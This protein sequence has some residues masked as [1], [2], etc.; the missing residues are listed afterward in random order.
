M[1]KRDSKMQLEIK[2]TNLEVTEAIQNYLTEKLLDLE[3][4]INVSEDTQVLA[5]VELAKN[6]EHHQ[7]GDD[8]FHAEINLTI[9]GKLFRVVSDQHDIYAAIDEMKDDIVR[10]VRKDKEKK[11]TLIRG[12]GRKAKEMLRNIF[13]GE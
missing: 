11:E 5:E 4:V 1:P 12:G 6:T 9:A 10:D 8:L 13:S 2:S 7:S 3:K